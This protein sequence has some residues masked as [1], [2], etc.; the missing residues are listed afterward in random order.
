MVTISIVREGQAASTNLM[1][2]LEVKSGHGEKRTSFQQLYSHGR[3][4]RPEIYPHGRRFVVE[5]GSSA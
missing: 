2:L 5:G 1:A 4:I 3:S